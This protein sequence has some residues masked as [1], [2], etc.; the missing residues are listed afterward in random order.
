MLV[1]D[2]LQLKV[3]LAKHIVAVPV[4]AALGVMARPVIG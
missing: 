3:P 2:G 1:L 4:L